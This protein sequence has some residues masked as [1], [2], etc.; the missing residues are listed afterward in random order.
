MTKNEVKL[1]CFEDTLTKK[2][3]IETCVAMAN[4]RL[5]SVGVE[6][7]MTEWPENKDSLY[8]YFKKAIDGNGLTLVDLEL[9]RG[10]YE[11]CTALA[12]R[13]KTEQQLEDDQFNHILNKLGSPSIT[14]GFNFAIV[15]MLT[16]QKHNQTFL[17]A[18]TSYRD[19]ATELTGDAIGFNVV[20]SPLNISESVK[21]EN[22]TARLVKEAKNKTFTWKNFLDEK[23]THDDIDS[24]TQGSNVVTKLC[25]LLDC[26]PESINEN[27]TAA[28]F[29]LHK[30]IRAWLKELKGAAEDGKLSLGAVWMLI[31]AVTRGKRCNI[32]KALEII[33]P[34]LGL[35]VVLA[36]ADIGHE[37]AEFVR[38]N[39]LRIFGELVENLVSNDPEE[40]EEALISV[41]L[42]EN[43]VSVQLRY[44]SV[45]KLGKRLA[46]WRS[47]ARTLFDNR[48]RNEPAMK[49]CSHTQITMP[50]MRF[51]IEGLAMCGDGRI[52][53]GLGSQAR[54][55][56]RPKD[57]G[58][59]VGFFSANS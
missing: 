35:P 42:E 29:R 33:P 22:L 34:T 24:A 45:E 20:D 32:K 55:E 37:D 4:D 9:V 57:A 53:F 8:G 28:K 31:S 38:R 1:F 47:P 17:I 52:Q 23:W 19:K 6:I 25:L 44:P 13:I 50:L 49:K 18:S 48:R 12:T 46:E 54:F 56:I 7:A 5:E 14:G 40:D 59:T 43:S 30:N 10:V 36:P 3:A 15:A 26:E 2:T 58:C 27:P 16:L 51:F 41:S 11:H 21:M 39:W